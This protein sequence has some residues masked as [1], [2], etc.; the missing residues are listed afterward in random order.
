[1]LLFKDYYNHERAHRGLDGTSPDDKGGFGVLLASNFKVNADMGLLTA[2]A[3]VLALVL[4]VL[5]LPSLLLLGRKSREA[6]G[7]QAPPLG[8]A[9]SES[10]GQW[11]FGGIGLWTILEIYL[12][13]PQRR[14]M[15]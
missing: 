8:D 2:L 1:M 3:I 11:Y 14:C 6:A 7:A 13:Q 12:H 10:G 4:D 5:L 15:G 9:D